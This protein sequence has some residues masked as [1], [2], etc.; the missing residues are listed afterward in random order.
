MLLAVVDDVALPIAFSFINSKTTVTYKKLF[1]A[2]SD[3]MHN[4]SVKMNCR[5]VLDFEDAAM[6]ALKGSFP[7]SE[8][9]G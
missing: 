7:E 8:I 2:I 6:K 3:D 5:I 1:T 4:N 9:T